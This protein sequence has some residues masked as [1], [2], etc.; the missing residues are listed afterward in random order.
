MINRIQSNG[1]NPFDLGET[2]ESIRE[3]GLPT[4]DHVA[5][6]EA[7]AQELFDNEKGAVAI[8]ALAAYAR[9]ANT[10]ANILAAGLQ[11]FYD[12]SYDDQQNVP[13]SEIGK[14][15]EFERLAN[16]YR[17]KRDRAYV[18]QA[19]CYVEIGELEKAVPLL[20]RSLELM[21]MEESKMWTA[22]RSLLY[23]IV[24]VASG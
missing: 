8:D 22:A 11:P 9:G 17:R 19:H 15:A 13:Q 20:I 23:R 16:A 14:L 3:H 24:G 2:E 12:A 4:V 5:H 18:R 10:L 1:N 6:L 7:K 21:S